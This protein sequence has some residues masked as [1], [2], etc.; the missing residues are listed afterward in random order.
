MNNNRYHLRTG[1]AACRLVKHFL[2]S[3]DCNMQ[4]HLSVAPIEQ[5]RLGMLG[6]R[7]LEDK[8][9][10]LHEREIFWQKKLMTFTPHGLNKREG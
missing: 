3:P 1:N 4:M 10:I 8:K 6:D 7:A 2:N 9:R 5:L